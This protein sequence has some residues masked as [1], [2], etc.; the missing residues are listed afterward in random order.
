LGNYNLDSAVDAADY[1]VWRDTLDSAVAAYSGAD[2]DGDGT[3][4]QDDYDVWKAHFGETV[5][6][7][8]GSG[9]QSVAAE[10]PHPSPLPEG[11]GIYYAAVG[12]VG[13]MD[14]SHHQGPR[15]ARRVAAASAAAS[16]PAHDGALATWVAERA[17]MAK[18]S[19]EDAGFDA[20]VRERDQGDL[21]DRVVDAVELAFASLDDDR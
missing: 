13:P 3:I 20:L 19:P 15:P 17:Q 18:H 7:G 21:P 9:A 6:P 16:A 11:E 1:T 10:D 2:G 4:D 14:R 12:A 8:A 5:P